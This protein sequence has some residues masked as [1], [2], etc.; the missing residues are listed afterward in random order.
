MN[1]IEIDGKEVIMKLGSLS[2]D[3]T[4]DSSRAVYMMPGSAGWLKKLISE[5][6]IEALNTVFSFPRKAKAKDF[7]DWITVNW[8]FIH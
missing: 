5:I 6:K 7:F 8:H 1:K 3:G 4:W 2:S